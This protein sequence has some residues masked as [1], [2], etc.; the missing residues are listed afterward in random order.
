MPLILRLL[1]AIVVC[2]ALVDMTAD[3]GDVM[4]VTVNPQVYRV[5][6][7]EENVSGSIPMSIGLMKGDILVYQGEGHV[8]RLPVGQD[9]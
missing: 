6:T 1:P 2:P 3:S 9:G 4:S 8:V 7:D 5:V